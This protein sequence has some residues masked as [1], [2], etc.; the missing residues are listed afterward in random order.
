[1]HI[2][3]LF[4]EIFYLKDEFIL[5][6]SFIFSSSTRSSRRIFSYDFILQRRMKSLHTSESIG[7]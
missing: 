6:L 4:L 2:I 7:M 5:F 3:P 1:M